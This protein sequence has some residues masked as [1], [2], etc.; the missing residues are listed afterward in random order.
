MHFWSAEHRAVVTG[1]QG[2][3]RQQS[4]IWARLSCFTE[5]SWDLGRHVPVTGWQLTSYSD[6]L[7]H[8]LLHHVA[9]CLYCGHSGS[10]SL[11]WSLTG[12]QTEQMTELQ[13]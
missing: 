5:K 2:W 6:G 13:S 8:W 4:I 12:I 11:P 10:P 1:E 3:M 7:R 9:P